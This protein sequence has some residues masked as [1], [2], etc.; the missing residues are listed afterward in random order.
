M[1]GEFTH[2]LGDPAHWAFEAVSGAV[3]AVPAVIVTKW[4]VR[5][6]DRKKHNI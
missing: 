5:I 2:L 1:W 4:R 6:H 3:Y